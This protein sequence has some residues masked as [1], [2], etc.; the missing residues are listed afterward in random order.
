MRLPV[1]LALSLSFVAQA[2]DGG[3][4][5]KP[6]YVKEL[7][8]AGDHVADCYGAGEDVA[9]TA[10][11]AAYQRAMAAPDATEEVKHQLFGDYLHTVGVHGKGKRGRGDFAGAYALLAPAYQ[12]LVE[13]WNGG[14]HFHALVDNIPLVGETYMAM[15]ATGKTSSARRIL[16]FNR[17][18]IE[19]FYE[20]R[21]DFEGQA[22]V[23][24]FLKL[25]LI[26]SEAREAELARFH[27]ARA[28]AGGEAAAAERAL[29]V[30]AF[31]RSETWL[32][33]ATDANINAMFD[34]SPELRFVTLKL[35]LGEL[36][37]QQGEKQQ[38]AREF[39]LAA[40]LSCRTASEDDRDHHLV[41]NKCTP[42]VAR[43]M[44][45]EG[46][47]GD[48][49]QGEQRLKARLATMELPTRY[50]NRTK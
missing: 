29:A 5:A 9:C 17:S 26:K 50:I 28:K 45:A 44:L 32:E 11:V 42:A 41:E 4:G 15:L 27:A 16:A 46:I 12:E 38:A 36:L 33:R 7:E 43:W 13:H 30:D 1:V 39:L 14:E 10:L 40:A 2:A 19:T 22:H 24:P 20:K 3:A 35:E 48:A 23:Q 25:A 47:L 8:A 49:A 31:R 34:G 18:S 6:Q 37:E 21:K